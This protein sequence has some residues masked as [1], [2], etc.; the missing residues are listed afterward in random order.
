MFELNNP[1]PVY[2]ASPYAFVINCVE[3]VGVSVLVGK[4]VLNAFVPVQVLFEVNIPEPVYVASAYAFVINCV[5]VVGVS[6]LVGKLVLN[7][8][9]PVHALFTVNRPH[10]PSTYDLFTS[11]VPLVKT[12]E[13]VGKLLKFTVVPIKLTLF[14]NVFV[15]PTHVLLVPNLPYTKSA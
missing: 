1:E 10:A 13:H 12:P 5:D 15:V 8:F 6:V 14:E 3:V 11:S 4:L 9:V 7:V 2:V